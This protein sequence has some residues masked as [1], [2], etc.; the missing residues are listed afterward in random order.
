[1]G[2]NIIGHMKYDNLL[3]GAFPRAT[4]AVVLAAGRKYPVGSVLGM[5]TA[6]GKCVLVDS[7]KSDGSE[8]PFGVL[9][10][11]VD[12][13]DEDDEGVVS[14]T[15]QFNQNSL[16]FGGSDTWETHKRAAQRNCLFFREPAP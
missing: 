2:L 6:T 12:A 16:T 11:A 8:V 5:V 10:S 9:M 15:G 13:T 14:L 4:E 7:S 1:M 3:A